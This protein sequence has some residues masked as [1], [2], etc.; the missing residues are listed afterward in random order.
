MYF[1]HAHTL[2]IYDQNIW[3]GK[4]HNKLNHSDREQTWTAIPLDSLWLAVGAE[5]AT[6][7]AD[8]DALNRGATDGAELTTKAVGDLELKVGSA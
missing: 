3:E 5:V 1:T 2:S 7:V 4:F 8:G 6:A